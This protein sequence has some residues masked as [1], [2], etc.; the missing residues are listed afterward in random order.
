[1]TLRRLALSLLL[2][3]LAA[4]LFVVFGPALYGPALLGRLNQ[5]GLSG[6]YTV[7]AASV[8]GPIW[9]PSARGVRIRGPGIDVR[10]DQASV[11]VSSLNP[12]AR[13]ARL[14]VALSG[15]VIDLRLKELLAGLGKQGAPAGSGKGGFQLLPGHLDIKGVAL[16]IDGQGANIPDGRFSVTGGDAGD[17]GNGQL[18]VRGQ[19]EYGN[20]DAVLDYTTASGTLG[21]GLGFTADARI[22]NHYWKPG[23]VTAGQVKGRYSLGTGPLSGEITLAG[24]ALQVKQAPFVT[25]SGVAGTFR[26]R[27]DQ[28]SGQ[29]TGRSLGGPV[30]AEARVDLKARHWQVNADARPTLSTLGTALKLPA[31]GDLRLSVQASGWADTKVTARLSSE[32]GAVSGVDFS[33]LSADYAFVS[34]LRGGKARVQTNRLSFQASTRF[35][36][37]AQQLAG[38]WDLNK[39]GQ[40]TLGGRLLNA[41]LGLV[42]Q[43]DS[44]NTVRVTGSALNGPVQASYRLPTR[45]LSANLRPSLAGLVGEL[46]A[47][48]TPDN[49]A[50]TVTKLTA[51]PLSLSG[52]GRLDRAGLRARLFQQGGGSLSLNTDRQFAGTW[53]LSNF[54]AA[55]A[56]ASGGGSVQLQTGLS[57]QL[58]ATAPGVTSVLSGPINL[59]WSKR[60]GSWRTGNAD[61]SWTGD[62]LRLDARELAASGVKLSGQASY[63]TPGRRLSLDARSDVLGERQTLTGGWTPGQ[64]GQFTLGGQLLKLPLRLSAQIDRANTLTVTGNAL[65]GPV[66]ASYALQGVRPSTGQP[67]TGQP[68]TGQLSASFSPNLGGVT[69]RLSVAGNLS[70]LRLSA[71]DLRAGPLTFGGQG[72]LDRAGLRVSLT[73]PGGGTVSLS[74]NRQFSGLWRISKLGAAGVS[75]S[76]SG[77]LDLR[78]GLSGTLSA[79]AP[80]IS[81]PLS[82][83]LSLAWTTRTGA[84]QTRDAGLRWQGDVFSLAAREL[85]ASGLSFSGRAAYTLSKQSLSGQVRALGQG[86]DVLIVGE[87]QQAR[88][89][90]NVRGVNLTA[91]SQLKA[92]Y[93][94]QVDVQGSGLSGSLSAENGVSFDLKSGAQRLRGNL[95]GQD[96]TVTGGL[97]LAA[98]RPLLGTLLRPL[99]GTALGP[100]TSDL[101]GLAR[102]DLAAQGGSAQ[103]DAK[104]NGAAL[105][106]RLTRRGGAVGAR[107]SASLSDLSALLSGQVYPAVALDGPFKWRGTG[108]PQTLQAQLSGPYSALAVRLDGQTAAVSTGGVELPSQRVRLRGSLTP[109]LALNGVWGDL[110]ATYRAGEV[111]LIGT[112]ALGVAGRSGSVHLDALW[113]PDDSGAV[114]ATG[115]FGDAQLGPLSFGASGPWTAL[116]VDLS[117]SRLRAQGRANVRT[118]QY[119]LDVSGPLAELNAGLAGLSLR[120]GLRGQG[121]RVSGAVSVSDAAGGSARLRLNSL[122][123]FA[124]EAQKLQV[125]GL[126]VAGQLRATGGLLSGQAELGPLRVQARDGAFTAL[127]ELYGQQLMASGRLLLPAGLSDLNLKVDGPYLSAQASGSASDLRGQLRLKAQHYSAAGL[128]AGLVAQTLP[129]RASL[130]PLVA[131]VGGLTYAGGTWSGN[132]AL[133]YVLNTTP[134][135]LRLSGQGAVLS[136]ATSG[137]LSGRVTVLPQLGG[138]LKLDLAALIRG[139]RLL[140]EQVRS[141]LVP[142]VLSASLAPQSASLQL[143]GGWWLGGPLGLSGSVN[144]ADGLRA[145]ALLTHPGSRVPVRFDAGVITV[146]NGLLDARAAL[147]ILVPGTPLSGTVRLDLSA[148]IRQLAQASG[149]LDVQLRSG[150]QAA[151]GQLSLRAGQLGGEL[152]SDIGGLALRLSGPLYPQADATFSLGDVR[153]GLRGG[154]R[155]VITGDA[156]TASAEARWTARV[157]GSYAGQAVRAQA[158][159]SSGAASLNSDVA[160]LSVNL[161]AIQNK[162]IWTLSGAANAAD[163]R[164][165]TGQSG[166]LTATLAGPLSDVRA[167]VG[168]TLAGA[169]FSV[170]ARYQGGVLSL[171]HAAVSADLAGKAAQATLSGAV[172]PALKLTGTAKLEAAPGTF[173]LGASGPL[174][175]PTIS[176]AGPLTGDALGLKLAGTSLSARLSGKDFVLTARGEALAGQARGRT[177]LSG[178]LSSARFTLHTA[179]QGDTTRLRLDGPLA[180]DRAVGW[181]GALRASGQ[182]PGGPLDAQL[183]GSGPLKLSASLGPARLSGQFPATL[184]AR[185]GGSLSLG[186][187]DLGAFWQRPGLLSLSGQVSLGGASW[188]ELSASFGG[189]LRD[190]GGDLSGDLSGTYTASNSAPGTA[191][192][193]LS[194]QRLQGQASLQGQAVSASLN[195]QNAGLARL[196]PPSFKVDSLRL[197]GILEARASTGNGLERLDIRSLLLSGAQAQVGPF[198]L[199]GSAQYVPGTNGAASAD[200]RGRAFGGT[201]TALGNFKQGLTLSARGL[202]LRSYGLSATSA[203]VTLG[204]DYAD[205]DLSG[206]LVASRAEGSATATLSGRV[207]DPQ[208]RVNAVLAA[209]YSGTVQADVTRLNLAKQTAQLR[210]SGFAA[211]NADTVS[212]DLSGVW[213]KLRGAATAS[214]SGLSAPVTLTG[215]GDGSYA[216]DAGTLGSGRLN[217]SSSHLGGSNLGDSSSGGLNPTVQ[218]SATLTPLPLLGASGQ[219]QLSVTASGPLGAL[220]LRAGG[221]FRNL[222]RSGV[223][224]PDT[225]LSVSGPVSKLSGELRQNGAAVATLSGDTLRFTNLTARVS[226]AELS[227]TGSASLSGISSSTSSVKNLVVAQLSARGSVDGAAQLSYGAGGLAGSGSLRAAGVDAAFRLSAS[228][229]LGWRG[230]LRLNG[231]PDLAGLGPVLSSPAVLSLGGP[232]AA[233][234]LS[235][236]LG[237]LGAHARLVADLQGAELSLQDGRTTRASGLLSLTRNDA[238]A[239]RWSGQI[240]ASRPEAALDLSLSGP[241]A[242]PNAEL[243][244]R[245]GGWSASGQ[246][247]LGAGALPNT[248]PNTLPNT[249][250]SA[251]LTLSDGAHSGLL[252]YDGKALRVDAQNL[253]LAKLEIG[254]LSGAV[255]AV[256][257]VDLASLSGGVQLSLSKLSSGARLPYFELPL[258]GSGTASLKLIGGAA[259]VQTRLTAPYGQLSLN[260]SQAGRGGPWSGDLSAELRKD[261]GRVLASVKLGEAGATGK[262][263]LSA[264][265]LSAAGVS[266]TLDGTV[267]LGGQN[268]VLSAVARTAVSGA[269]SAQS[270]TVQSSSAQISGDG[271][272]ADLLPALSDFTVLR[273][274]EA[275]YRLQVGLSSFDL[276]GLKLGPARSAPPVPE[277][278]GPEG[279]GPNGSASSG[280][281]TS[282]NPTSSTNPTVQ[283]SSVLSASSVLNAAGTRFVSP[284]A[285]TGIG[286]SVSGQ[287]TLSQ[288]SGNFVLRSDR[289]R[290]GDASFPA[291]LDGNLAGGD[292]RLRGFVGDS[293]FFGALTGGQLTVRAQLEALPVGN[294]V[295][296]FSGKLPG[297]GVV[298]GVARIDAPLSDPTSGSLAL[299]A[300]RV[301]VTSGRETLTGSGTVDFR[302]RELRSLNLKLGGAGQW[303]IS[304]QYTRNLVD[305]RAVFTDTT[306][307]P[308]LAFVPSLSGAGASLRGSLSLGVGGTYDRPTARLSGQNLTGSVAGVSVSLPSLSGQLENSGQFSAQASIQAAGSLGAVGRVDLTGQLASGTLS[309][310]QARYKGSLSADALGN[311]GSLNAALIQ[312]GATGNDS[313]WTLNAAATQG[314]TLTLQGQLVPRL[315]LSLNAANYNLPFRTIY[316]RESS[317]N[318]SLKATADGELIRVGGALSFARL[319]LGRVGTTASLPGNL[320]A[321]APTSGA[322]ASTLGSYTSPLP[323]A[324]TVFAAPGAEKAASP[325]LQRLVFDD[326]PIRAPNGVRVDENLA[327]AELSASLSLSGSGA[328]PRL[329]GEVRS[330]RGNLLLRDN[331]FNLQRALATF[332]GSSLYPVFS[333][334]ARGD[335]PSA[336]KMI[337]VQ[338]QADGSFVVSAGARALKLGTVLSCATCPSSDQYSQAEL[339]S[340]LAL[341]TPDIT[342]LGS[343]VGALGQNAISTALNLFVLSELQRNIARALGV[344]VFRISSNLVTPEGNLD[345]KFTVGTYLSRQFYVQYQVDLSGKGVFDATFTTEGDRFTFRAST[346]ISGLDLQSVRPSLS[347]AYN[348][349]PRSSLKLGVQSGNVQQGSN[350]KFSV[351]YSYRW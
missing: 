222:E 227:A 53:Q 341:G 147:P 82:G 62:V 58:S 10:A 218:A 182:A 321:A 330:L 47:Q 246:A 195:A 123:S 164:A 16:N 33:K 322:A 6:P 346:P 39:S 210:L 107:V 176:L 274:S 5:S 55:G 44:A 119:A 170:P 197:S 141:G 102:F 343:N 24:G 36:N 186:S 270:S 80:G 295:S 111:A 313:A 156:R 21:A 89:S 1:M 26:Q 326:I 154:L 109:V 212:F 114:T 84:W 192:L 68:G 133:R 18:R 127:G 177:D 223:T 4:L 183:S 9:H 2:V 213:P 56:A 85:R 329:S 171:Q 189:A 173:T 168:G 25:A 261:A 175:A 224:L 206:S 300:E 60:S 298:T 120:G 253:D 201:L 244:V 302:G 297:D 90:G 232:Y 230:E 88:L 140:P 97:D 137:S 46:G 50:L 266:A 32:Q 290:L 312:S 174:G 279:S 286:G 319:V 265:P 294:I 282:S 215:N 340:L 317:L 165:L 71:Q 35:Q 30:S 108:G 180:W 79:S 146:S 34:R 207:R 48:G 327:Q 284:A 38:R 172:Y 12:L 291:R 99:P 311:L 191:R 238:G 344:D 228:E 296:G 203:D 209:P 334:T 40:F 350:T 208:L 328:A 264:L 269:Q 331:N 61:L 211:R 348:L 260:A 239:Y 249:Q 160:G 199:S 351:G 276:A 116:K 285:Q 130:T 128:S 235:G 194:G 333:L 309:R 349:S 219:G 126:K 200:L 63:S 233:P 225:A 315:D 245:R 31:S 151:A 87:G 8:S 310:T 247:S 157:G 256:G 273:P 214:L 96:W 236:A 153:G 316:A 70:E 52:Q 342:T 184:P 243:S 202:D 59:N 155:G 145:A 143:S 15:G 166:T 288:G 323:D 305:L 163:L 324:L 66:Q 251:R 148:P 252:S 19:T 139:N 110:R 20:A 234:Q 152:S 118:L 339:Y 205:P 72:T 41:P 267:D 121:S 190:Q 142:G 124:L 134:G 158:T 162:S 104:L 198:R 283:S 272:L 149:Q 45:Q 117:A 226:G 318:G 167:Q 338:L 181:T 75:A 86:A 51:G 332:D 122:T 345:A 112:Q 320:G 307:T 254:S 105:S 293:T 289:L 144:W 179:Y 242:A 125:G 98:L 299:V 135:Q 103:V 304:G 277:G 257:A 193:S 129:L 92:P 43:I 196:L 28:I 76:G 259:Q 17:S 314:G 240:R 11:G 29:L 258:E 73:Q 336:G 138:A 37:E 14:N 54:G 278:S 241:L 220:Q 306:F 187:L 280:P 255:S 347:V 281:A 216:L 64:A 74:T 7:S 292:W 204:G 94:T 42:A 229:R 303:D 77:A 178:Y 185:P 91:L 13:S 23:G 250:P 248:Q 275:G 335:V 150:R 106:A 237:L 27:G 69:G 95:N 169:T 188:S 262:V 131:R 115:Q 57:G 65:G 231:G 287:L 93:S 301:R 325:F 268:F 113:R 263:T 3:L 81:S 217:L 100:A 337:G 132:A 49:L 83:P 159:L 308:V 78:R 101:S 161:S 67:G 221:T 271:N 22:V 136:A